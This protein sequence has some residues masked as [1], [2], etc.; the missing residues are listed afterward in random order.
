MKEA[1]HGHGVSFRARSDARRLAAL[2]PDAAWEIVP[3]AGHEVNRDA[4][5]ALAARLRA[6]W[7]EK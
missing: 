2:L 5:E 6:F 3:G 4:P 1:G 7:T